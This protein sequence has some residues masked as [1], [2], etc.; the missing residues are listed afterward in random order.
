MNKNTKA[1]PKRALLSVAVITGVL[2]ALTLAAQINAQEAAPSATTP[3]LARKDMGNEKAGK[4][5]SFNKT[6]A[7]WKELLDPEQYRILREKGTEGAFS[8]SLLN[9]KDD[10]TFTCAGCGNELFA[11]GTKFDSGCGW[12]SFTAP[13]AE[14]NVTTVVDRSLGM[15]RIE[16]MCAKCGGHLGHVFNDGPGPTGLRYCINSV[17]LNF[18][19]K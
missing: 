14:D 7:E 17:S 4:M 8:G 12:P 19:K 15:E 2:G 6:D 3:I 11:T 9:V 16:V 1:F 13:T 18:D 10:G 5:N